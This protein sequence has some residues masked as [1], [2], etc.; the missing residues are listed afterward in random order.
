MRNPWLVAAVAAAPLLL[1]GTSAHAYYTATIF[2]A[3]NQPDLSQPYSHSYHSS[4]GWEDHYNTSP[5]L[6]FFSGNIVIEWF[7]N[8]DVKLTINSSMPAGGNSGFAFADIFF[9][10][11]NDGLGGANTPDWDYGLDINSGGAGFGQTTETKSDGK[12]YVKPY[13]GSGG[14]GDKARL[15]EIRGAQDY[16]FS[17]YNQISNTKICSDTGGDNTDCGAGNSGRRPEVEITRTDYIAEFDVVQTP[18]TTPPPNYFYSILMEGVNLDGAWNHFRLFWGTGWCAN[19]TVE[20]YAQVPVPA[21][22][23]IMAASL[24]GFAFAGWRRNRAI[25]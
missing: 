2:D 20:G 11:A 25:A 22:L 19:D 12:T 8:G 6:P 5:G 10:L 24:A 4:Q 7:D 16:A 18:D 14:G 23:P 17:V 1:S 9:D 13:S 15:V 21:A 3:Y